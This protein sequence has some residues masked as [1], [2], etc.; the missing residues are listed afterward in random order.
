MISTLLYFDASLLQVNSVTEGDI[1]DNYTTFFNPGTIDNVG[2]SVT[3]IFGLVIG[4]GNVSG[5]GS[6]ITIS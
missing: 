5:N 2:G 3:N 6:F 1:F 4:Q